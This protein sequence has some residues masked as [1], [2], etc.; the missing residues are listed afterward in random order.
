MKIHIPDKVNVI[1]GLQAVIDFLQKQDDNY[2]FLNQGGA[3]L[4]FSLH[5]PSGFDSKLNDGYFA[6]YNGRMVDIKKG[7]IDLAKQHCKEDMLNKIDEDVFKYA[8]E[9]DDIISCCSKQIEYLEEKIASSTSENIK[10]RHRKNIARLQ[11][12]KDEA[13]AKKKEAPDAIR[14]YEKLKDCIENNKIKWTIEISARQTNYDIQNILVRPCIDTDDSGFVK[15]VFY[16][17]DYFSNELNDNTFTWFSLKKK[18]YRKNLI[19]AFL[20]TLD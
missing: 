8:K 20:E 16:Y 14:F 6:F 3:N 19:K 11:A 17:D 12:E 9:P 7:L 2:T 18:Y 4:Y 15:P 10:N 1:N 5:S 13:E